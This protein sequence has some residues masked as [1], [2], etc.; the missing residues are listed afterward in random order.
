MD[1]P[2]AFLSI[3]NK[4]SAVMG[5][6]FWDGA[7]I[8]QATQGSLGDDGV[9]VPGSDPVSHPCRVQIDGADQYMKANAGFADNEVVM[10]ILAASLD[11]ALDTDAVLEIADV[12]APSMF[13][14][15]WLVSSLTLDPAGIGYGGK[16][17]RE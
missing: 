17:R 10:I 7:I 3:A 14:G 8:V 4:V 13:R 1:L 6:P 12:K 11:I 9:Y 16:G 5:A 2:A 15:K